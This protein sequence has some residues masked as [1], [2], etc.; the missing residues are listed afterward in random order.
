MSI[1]VRP[2]NAWQAVDLGVLMAR[3]WY[4]PLINIWLVIS[5]P[6][7]F[8]LAW[9][10]VKYLWFQAVIIWWLKPYFEQALLEFLSRAVFGD[11]PSVKEVIKVWP[12]L[13][14]SQWLSA[15]TWRRLS[16][17]RSMNLPV[18]Q[19]EGLRG[20]VRST[21]IDLLHREH[22]R[23]AAWLTIIGV[24]IE[25]FMALSASF[26]ILAFMPQG[27]DFDM[28]KDG[29]E[30]LNN[31][32][33]S[34]LLELLFNILMYVSAI[35]FAPFYVAAG[36][37][38][39]LN[40][41]VR[42]EAWDIDIAFRKIAE[43]HRSK[44]A[45]SVSNGALKGTLNDKLKDTLKDTS[46]IVS[47]IFIG[48]LGVVVSAFEPSNKALSQTQSSEMT[49]SFITQKLIPE[50][51]IDDKN[52]ISKE[53]AK[54]TINWIKASDHFHQKEIVRYPKID[55]NWGDQKQENQKSVLP[56]WLPGFLEL[57]FW[58][59]VFV[60]FGWILFRYR[61]WLIK[62][63]TTPLHAEAPKKQPVVMFGMDIRQQS[64]P[65]NVDQE[66]QK[67]IREGKVRE[68]LSLLY[69]ACLAY[70]VSAGYELEE[71]LTEQECLSLILSQ[72]KANVSVSHN[73][74]SD[75][76]SNRSSGRPSV[77]SSS[78]FSDRD[79][80]NHHIK[81]LPKSA[82]SYFQELTHVWRKLAYAHQTPSKDTLESL[83]ENWLKQWLTK[84][85]AEQNFIDKNSDDKNHK[86]R[87]SM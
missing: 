16:P 7:F 80:F 32:G 55:W 42:L 21:R 66:A 71:S 3:R 81:L 22:S 45:K 76:S 78:K 35:F 74:S 49:N 72:Q 30:L 53:S 24:H 2:R 60:V 17:S 43:K 28:V 11:E 14:G 27:F 61:Y 56:V 44:V 51:L 62:F 67:L 39:Y 86:D 50:R 18:T 34:Y 40:R 23:P 13:L 52:D 12:K 82:L 36:F 48:I 15:L 5:L 41:R 10:P 54:H 59:A 33:K 68:A 58:L 65:K 31:D 64:L 70:L 63:I 1:E 75:G 69:R 19:L 4:W 83:S 8:V 85:D 79:T 6:V 20:S 38:L 47:I 46:K 84:I 26:L 25:F 77:D 9:I 87:G 73:D 37:A 57:I 29:F